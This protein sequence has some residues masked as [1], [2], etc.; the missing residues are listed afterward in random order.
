MRDKVSFGQRVDSDELTLKVGFKDISFVLKNGDG[1]VN[2]IQSIEAA[3][4]TDLVSSRT[5][6]QVP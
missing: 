2:R 6:R 3:A 5:W 4:Y 1:I